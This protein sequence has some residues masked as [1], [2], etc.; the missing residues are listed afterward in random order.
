MFMN[1][2]LFG[3]KCDDLPM[4]PMLLCRNVDSLPFRYILAPC[5]GPF[6]GK[7]MPK[8][9]DDYVCIWPVLRYSLAL[10][11]CIPGNHGPIDE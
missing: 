1:S 7:V 3:S 11:I 5:I 9:S 4:V 10:Y 2:Y 6:L 8:F